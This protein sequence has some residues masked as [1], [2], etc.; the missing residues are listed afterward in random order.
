MVMAA[1]PPATATRAS[2]RTRRRAPAD[3]AFLWEVAFVFMV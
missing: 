1:M 3:R 2:V